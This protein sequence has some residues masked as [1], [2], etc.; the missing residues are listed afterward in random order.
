MAMSFFQRIE[1]F[2]SCLAFSIRRLFGSKPRLELDAYAATDCG[3]VRQNN[4]DSLFMSKSTPFYAVCDGMGGT[5]AGEVASAMMVEALEQNLNGEASARRAGRNTTVVRAARKV[6]R[7]IHKYISEH[8]LK[9]MGTTLV[10]LRLDPLCP[11]H[12][13]IC[14]A[15]D[16]RAYRVRNGMMELLTNDHS[17]ARKVNIDDKYLTPRQRNSLTNAIGIGKKC[18]L[19]QSDVDIHAGDMFILCSDGLYKSI[20]DNEILRACMDYAGKSAEELC[21]RLMQLALDAGG[22]DNVSVVI[23]K[24]LALDGIPHT[25]RWNFK[26]IEQG[27]RIDIGWHTHLAT[28][29]TA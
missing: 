26:G 6:N 10:S 12:G 15:G 2:L 5:D 3:K 29:H 17:Y 27:E 21:M 20:D 1:D 8:G 23:V 28:P 25:S 18:Y 22:R 13:I 14:H 19:E 11:A 16:S 9:A 4:E 7:D 24:I